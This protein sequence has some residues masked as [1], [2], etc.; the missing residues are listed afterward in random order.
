MQHSLSV[1]ECYLVRLEGL[2]TGEKY[3]IF[4]RKFVP[5]IMLIDRYMGIG[6]QSTSGTRKYLCCTEIVYGHPPVITSYGFAKHNIW[7]CIQKF[8]S[9]YFFY[10]V[11]V[12]APK[13]PF[14]PQ[15]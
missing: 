8:G 1:A 4:S 7:Y 14:L 12:P 11:P 6:T 2:M 5:Q 15:F 9:R 10:A 13:V 3:R